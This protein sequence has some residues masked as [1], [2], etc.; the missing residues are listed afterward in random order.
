[1]FLDKISCEHLPGFTSWKG[2]HFHDATVPEVDHWSRATWWFILVALWSAAA[3]HMRPE[4]L[5]RTRT[6]TS[7]LF[8]EVLH[9][10]VPPHI[11]GW[12]RH[13]GSSPRFTPLSESVRR[14]GEGEAW[15]YTSPI[16]SSIYTVHA[17]CET[18][19]L[20][21]CFFFPCPSS[22]FWLW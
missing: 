2:F 10:L 15:R 8:V 12:E 16:M 21:C 22:S 17:L 9:R 11:P 19:R 7:P 20:G 6:L 3:L 1:M 18:A 5:I 4:K 14:L 13:R